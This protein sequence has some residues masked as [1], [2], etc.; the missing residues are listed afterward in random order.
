MIMEEGQT[1]KF[2]WAG[3][4]SPARPPLHTVGALPFIPGTVLGLRMETPFISRSF[5]TVWRR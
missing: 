5:S 2:S 3:W 4:I 1:L